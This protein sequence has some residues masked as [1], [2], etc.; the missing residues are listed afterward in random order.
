MVVGSGQSVCTHTDTHS[1]IASTVHLHTA[2]H[3]A[4]F[5][6]TFQT[7]VHTLR[8]P[9]G[10]PLQTL[11]GAFTVTVTVTWSVHS[12][13]H[14]LLPLCT[15]FLFYFLS[16]SDIFLPEHYLFLSLFVSFLVQFSSA[17]P[18]SSNPPPLPP[19]TLL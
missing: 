9:T 1:L 11:L 4:T 10:S 13:G 18:P 2:F 8:S 3:I 6:P 15:F 12:G 5:I 7:A 14:T 16:H 17:R 19:S